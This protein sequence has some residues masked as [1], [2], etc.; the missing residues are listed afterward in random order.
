YDPMIAK[1]VTHAPTRE[2]A[3]AAQSEALDAFAIAGIRHNIPFLS[4]IMQN[5]RWI[6]GALSTGFI[7]EEFPNGFG[8]ILPEGKVAIRM[9]AVAA[10]IDHLHNERK[11]AIS[12]Q[13]RPASAV[14]FERDRV[15]MLAREPHPVV[16]ED[17]GEGVG[18]VVA[19]T[20]YPVVSDWR[21]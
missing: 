19:G 6:A 9:I 4:A 5:P 16:V 1:L 18:V 11:R 17:A 13:M 21:P 20:V 3:I 14:T 12:G 7:A 10:A 2:E 15:V 8:T